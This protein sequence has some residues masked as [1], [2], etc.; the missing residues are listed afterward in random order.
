M[1]SYLKMSAFFTLKV[2]VNQEPT[3][4]HCNNYIKTIW[5]TSCYV[6]LYK[7]NIKIFNNIKDS[8]MNLMKKLSIGLIATTL[9]LAANA[10]FMTV[11]GSGGFTPGQALD[12]NG[13]AITVVDSGL[14][15]TISWGVSTGDGQSRLELV[16]E[17]SQSIDLLDHN[18]LLSTLTHY[19]NDIDAAG[20]DQET[21]LSSAIIS[22]LLTLTGT[23]DNLPNP[24]AVPTQFDIAFEETRNVPG[25]LGYCNLD[26]SVDNGENF[27]GDTE[28]HDH[29]TNCDDR[30]D[31]SVDGGSFPITV[32]VVISGIEYYLTVFASTDSL[33]IDVITS[34]R[35]WTPEN[36]DTSV[37]T[38]AR[39]ARV[40]E[41]TSIAILALGLLGLASSRKRKS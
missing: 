29:G 7:P 16:D 36:S 24:F 22:G 12:G 32:P 31:Y 8:K 15:S 40:P 27:S 11:E 4:T 6:R 10:S 26:A 39:L 14:A 3:P 34:N 30:F 23:F 38:F 33:G 28:Q 19:N 37:Y 25:P 9:S 20:G 21:W 18:Y 2:K 1:T 13:N 5:H 41:P 17:A 35:F